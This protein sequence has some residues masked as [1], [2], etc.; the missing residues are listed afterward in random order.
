MGESLRINRIRQKWDDGQSALVAW[1][2]IPSA[3][4][5]ELLA[6]LDFDGVVVDLQHST[7]DCKTAIEMFTAAECRGCEPLVRAGQNDFTEI[8]KLLDGGASGIIVPL[9][10]SAEA[11]RRLV[12]SVHYPPLGSRSLGPRRPVLRWGEAYRANTRQYLVSLAMIETRPGLDNLDDIL[13][14]P[15]LD[16]VFV[17]PSDLALALGREPEANI[18]DEQVLGAISYI[19]ERA[20]G[21]GKRVGIFCAHPLAARGR[22]DEGFDLVSIGT[23]SQLLRSAALEGLTDLRRGSRRRLD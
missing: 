11:A 22:I 1:L 7:I 15:D 13:A 6:S 12:D 8:G 9:I 5:A 16:G 17:G 21:A 23:D 19:R 2:H 3:Y 10:E 14:T 4:S 18:R 20:H